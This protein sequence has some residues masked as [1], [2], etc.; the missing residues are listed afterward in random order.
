METNLAHA[1]VDDWVLLALNGDPR[2]TVTNLLN[3]LRENDAAEVDE[4]RAKVSGWHFSKE[5]LTEREREM[6]SVA[7][8]LLRLLDGGLEQ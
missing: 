1:I 4:L 5:A 2:A 6:L 3:V 7:E 8:D